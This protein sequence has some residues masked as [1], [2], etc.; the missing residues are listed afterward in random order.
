MRAKL[1]P[2][3]EQPKREKKPKKS[4]SGKVDLPDESLKDELQED[5]TV[6]Q[7]EFRIRAKKEAKRLEY[8]TDAE[9]WLCVVFPTRDAK[10]E[11]LAETGLR[12]IDD[13]YID[14]EDLKAA[15]GMAPGFRKPEWG[16][17]KISPRWVKHAMKK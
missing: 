11:F 8:T 5:I 13:R 16:E 3:G 15:M 9:Y 10:D 6:A 14:S 12:D 4:R 1:K 17:T 2:R 7:A